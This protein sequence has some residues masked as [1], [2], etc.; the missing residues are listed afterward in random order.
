MTWVNS[1]YSMI[2]A[3]FLEHDDFQKMNVFLI[4]MLYENDVH[5][6][7]EGV[8]RNDNRTTIARFYAR[9]RI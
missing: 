8:E 7:E 4:G 1:I 2:K 9:N 5:T 6:R 3:T